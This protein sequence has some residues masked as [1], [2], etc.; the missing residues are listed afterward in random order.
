MGS[1]ATAD[2]SLTPYMLE[3][4]RAY[5]AADKMRDVLRSV[6]GSFEEPPC[7]LYEIT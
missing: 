6:I 5:A 3:Y 4:V 2:A 7:R 1:A